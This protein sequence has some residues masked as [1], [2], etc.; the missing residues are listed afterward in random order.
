MRITW[1]MRTTLHLV[2]PEDLEWLHPLFAPRQATSNAR[3]L[4]QLG[5]SEEQA[6]RAVELD[7]GARAGEAP[8]ARRAPRRAR[9]PGRG[10]GD[11]PPRAPRRAAGPRRARPPSASSSRSSSARPAIAT[12]ALSELARRYS[13]CHA[14]AHRRR[15]RLL[16]R[17]A[18]ARRA[19]RPRTRPGTPARSRASGSRPSTSCC[20]AGATARRPSRRGTPARCTRAAAS[21]ARW[22]SRTAWRRHVERVRRRAAL[23]VARSGRAAGSAASATT[24]S[25]LPSRAIS[26]GTS[27][28]RTMKASIRTPAAVATPI[29]WM[30]EIEEV[31]K[32][33]IAT[34]SRIAAAVTTAP[35]R[36]TPTATASLSLS[37]PSRAS[38]MRP[39]QEHA[40]VGREREHERGGDQEVGR[41]DA[42]VGRVA[43]QALEAPVLEDERE[44]AERRADGQR[45][46]QD[47]L[48]RQHDRAG[49]Q[50]QHDEGQRD[51][52][53]E[54][55][56][57]ARGDRVLLVDERRRRRRRRARPGPARSSRTTARAV[58]PSG[59]ARRQHV[60]LVGAVVEPARLGHRAHARQRRRSA[61]PA[62]GRRV[63]TM[64][65]LVSRPPKSRSSASATVREL[66]PLR[67]HRGVDRRPHG[68]QRGQREEQHQRAGGERDR[69]R[70]AHH[71]V[72]E[73]VPA[74]TA[75]AARLD[76]AA[77]RPRPRS[78]AGAITERRGAGDE[79]HDRAGDPHRLQEAEREDGQRDQRRGDGDRA[80]DDGAPGGA[81]RR[82]DRVR[83]LLGQ[84]LAIAG[85]EEE[86]VVDRQ[87][88]AR[89][90]S[91]G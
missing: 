49:H 40:V 60:D 43:E 16:V 36:S 13:A 55:E 25:S 87:A 17:P 18:G 71:G 58:S 4:R 29:C 57:E 80:E 10:P 23:R 61:R 5:V 53:R 19:P 48:E 75:R 88:R 7:R 59:V 41:L 3:R 34:A 68:A 86:R 37:P 35:V 91:R 76:R 84:L 33:P 22:C 47:R 28:A 39:E 51:E 81:H 54:G 72:R 66:W 82:A 90:R 38:L 15:P 56:R 78:V 11:R 79:R 69:Q 14:G 32:A 20:S 70:A 31:M 67:D 42:A 62:T 74:A 77:S 9:H 2:Q 12:R 24:S 64:I 65:G 73:P 6:D 89:G 21:S 8:R 50:P 1:L 44:D 30:K 46:H 52:Q 63:T 85:D 83:V 45:V 26:D 27:S